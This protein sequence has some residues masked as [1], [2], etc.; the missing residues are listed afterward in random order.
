MF[1]I[2]IIKSQKDGRLY[3]GL[4]KDI[5]NR[6]REH[7]NGKQKSTKAY[8]PWELIYSESF[9]SRADARK[10]EKFFKSGTGR[11]YLKKILDL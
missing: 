3:K 1:F 11:E 2:Y 4:T 5:L 6:L 8:R 9:N 10:R 7:N